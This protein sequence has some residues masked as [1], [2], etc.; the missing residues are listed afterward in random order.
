MFS[1]SGFSPQAFSPKSWL[2]TPAA[3]DAATPRAVIGGGGRGRLE[4]EDDLRALVE[5]KWEAIEA[6]LQA[7]EHPTAQQAEAQ[8]KRA[9]P[10]SRLTAALQT[11][12]VAPKDAVVAGALPGRAVDTVARPALLP[13]AAERALQ[14]R[15]RN[16]EEALLLLLLEA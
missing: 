6:A 4:S 9:N 14:A 15:R 5:A 12:S 7:E 16:D 13:G 10:G 3:E 1:R 2:L 8:K 11:A